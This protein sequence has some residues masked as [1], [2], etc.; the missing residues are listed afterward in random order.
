[1]QKKIEEN[2]LEKATDNTENQ[3]KSLGEEE[4][5]IVESVIDKRF[6]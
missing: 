5:F 1:M 2:T 3:I 6:K 4:E